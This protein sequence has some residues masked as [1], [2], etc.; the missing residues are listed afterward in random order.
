MNKYIRVAQKAYIYL[1]YKNPY[2]LYIFL[3]KR[4]VSKI[5]GYPTKLDI[6]ATGICN[7][8][9]SMC[10]CYRAT[11]IRNNKMLSFDDFKKII[12]DV[13]S[14]CSEIF[15]S[16][17]GEPLLNNEIYGMIEYAKSKHIHTGLTTNGSAL[18][19]T[20]AT[21]LIDSNP[22]KIIISLDASESTAYKTMR[23]GGDFNQVIEGIS[24]L[25]QENKKNQKKTTQIVLQMIIT[26]KNEHQLN[27]FIEL[28]KELEVDLVSFRSLFIDHRGDKKYVDN[29]IS[30]YLTD[31][32][33]SRYKIDSNSDIELKSSGKCPSTKLPIIT[34]DGDIAVCCHD[35]F[36]EHKQGN[37][38]NN[39]FKKVWNDDAYVKFRDQVMTNRKLSICRY[40]NYSNRS[41]KLIDINRNAT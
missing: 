19:M 20:N 29:L 18:T 30:N 17:C 13:E 31:H 15:F 41:E 10:W 4:L 6:E 36:A 40:C 37:I 14:Y 3:R 28:A 1:R 16:G 21:R 9:C 26:K 23:I 8:T 22:D 5:Y 24:N 25:S 12:D 35:I 27:D 33:I 34:S 2:E 7:F 38:I 32:E 39:S 11:D